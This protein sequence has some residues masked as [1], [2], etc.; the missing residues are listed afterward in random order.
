MSILVDGIS[1][2]T[3]GLDHWFES[4]DRG[5]LCRSRSFVVPGLAPSGATRSKAASVCRRNTASLPRQ[6]DAT[7]AT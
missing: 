5:N 4:D 2:I 1:V 7:S 3:A 6:G